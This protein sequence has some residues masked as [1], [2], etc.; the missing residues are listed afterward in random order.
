MYNNPSLLKGFKRFLIG[1]S[2]ELLLEAR[3]L[4]NLWLVTT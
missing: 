2:S 4:D 1:G 3:H